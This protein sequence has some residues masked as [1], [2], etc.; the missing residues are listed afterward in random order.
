MTA[1]PTWFR[2]ALT[3]VKARLSAIEPP[4]SARLQ[5]VLTRMA[6]R[7]GAE[8]LETAFTSEAAMPYPRLTDAYR[9][10]VGIAP[11]DG[12]LVTLGEGA[13]LLYLQVRA[14]DDLVDDPRTWDAGTTYAAEVFSAASVRSFADALGGDP[15]FF[16]FREATLFT[17]LSAATWELDV[18]R[19]GE[20]PA[21]E[22]IPRMGNKLLPL[23]IPLGALA[24]AAERADDLDALTAF[25]RTIGSGLQIVNDMLNIA[26]DHAA[27][28]LSPVLSALYAGGRAAPGA[29]A[30]SIRPLFLSD[31]ALDHALVEARAAIAK[32]A[33]IAA[34]RGAVT[35]AAAA[36]ESA[37]L[38]D[39]APARLL[40]L[41]LSG[42]PGKG[43][44]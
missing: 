31:A 25:A 28:R 29:P 23:A 16:A 17:F 34:Q 7:N 14:Q 6:G 44:R 36:R 10:D 40:G 9:N 20:G 41:S 22:A 24:L 19:L 4:L 39:S 21:A 8:D 35:L 26:E 30:G 5:A 33:E 18:Y 15:R 38:I 3:R 43:A 42:S 1:A 11:F 12:R 32:A 13:I 37:A 27:G 2:A